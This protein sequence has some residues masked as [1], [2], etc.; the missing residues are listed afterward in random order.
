MPI[1]GFPD[2]VEIPSI[3]ARMRCEQCGKRGADVRPDWSVHA[4]PPRSGKGSEG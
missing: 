1:D 4:R 3:G 2:D